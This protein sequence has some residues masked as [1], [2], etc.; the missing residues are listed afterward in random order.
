MG[1]AVGFGSSLARTV[2]F[3]VAYLGATYAGRLTVM[4]ATNLSLVWPAAGVSAVWAVV[5]FRSRWRTL[6]VVALSGVTIVVN[7]VTGAPAV[8]AGWFVAA[9]LL[10]A[11]IF[12]RLC[13]RWLPDAWGG[14]HVQPLSRLTELWRLVAAAFLATAGG[15]LVG[16]TGLWLTSGTYSWAATA[17]WLTRNTVSILL[18]G[19]A[20]VLV[21]K[22]LQT[23]WSASPRVSWH[24]RW[25]GLPA[26]RRAEYVSLTVLSIAVYGVVFGLDHRLPL[27][28]LVIALT[29]W[30][31]LR[32]NTTFVVLHDLVFGSVTVVFTLHGTGVFAQI[33]SHPARAMV[34][35]LFVG[36]IAVAGL[37]LALGRDDR[38]A[39]LASLTAAE[40]SAAR[41]A[42]MMGAIIDAMS[43]GLTVVDS[44]GRFLLRNPAVRRLMRGVVSDSDTMAKPEY[45]GLFHPDGR[46]LQPDEMPYRRA[47]A[48]TDVR[49]MDILIRNPGLPDGRVLSVSAVAL[50]EED[51]GRYA[52]SVFHDVTAERRHRDELAAFAGAVAHDLQNPL[53]TVEGWSEALAE[54]IGEVPEHAARAELADAVVRIRRASARM[55]N[56]IND[57]LEYTTARDAT[58]SPTM[59]DLGDLVDD[60]AMAR[61][62]Q[63]QSNGAP[64]P[65]F[66]VGELHPAYADP[67]LIR[68]LLENLLGN[69]IKYTARGTAAR[70]AVATEVVDEMVTV[71]IDDNGIGIPEGQHE[72]VFDN[73]HRAHRG[74]GHS[75]TGLGLGICKRIVERH[76][77]TIRATGNPAGSGTRLV[78]TLPATPDALA[79][80]QHSDPVTEADQAGPAPVGAAPP[81]DLSAGETDE[82]SL[83]PAATFEHAARLILDYL[84]DRIPLAFWAVTRV[85]NG[86]QTY[87][88]LDADNGYGL[89]QGESHPWQ[90][91]FCMHM[92]AG[93][94][95]SVARDAQQV[96]VYAAAGVNQLIDIGTYAGAAI[97]EPDGTLFGAICG[98]DPQTHTGDPRMTDAEPLLALLGRL[99]TVALAADRARD[100]SANAML[101]QQLSAETDALTGLPNR[102][103]W[104]RLIE[105]AETRFARLADPTVIAVLDLDGL[106][107]I[108]DSQGHGAGDTY[109]IVAAAAMHRA[110]RDTDVVARLGGD[111]FGFLLHKCTEDDAP[112]V[113]ARISA[114]LGKAGVRASIGW[115][116]VTGAESFAATVEKADAAMYATK[117]KNRGPRQASVTAPGA[118]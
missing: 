5:Q 45:Y 24:A 111:E 105:Q 35:Q 90:D 40:R 12:A 13:H 60:I 112:A 85:E 83:R 33:A 1:A 28:F 100:R 6:D 115:H 21:G 23:W 82:P 76:G 42:R 91:S 118:A 25:A 30:A 89:H 51:G 61:I 53:A 16:P 109:L 80:R 59:V 79:A 71:T 48:G 50:P 57:L 3:A 32:L 88:Y 102:R 87:L 68:Q 64:I 39:L 4:D 95:P 84:H 101:H 86:R 43:E 27:A 2:A 92:A 97:T 98:L 14:V 49:D 62:D 107:M 36:M 63:A 113:V 104:Q 108:N 110:L 29:M 44:Q 94:A 99:L 93:Q 77:G 38:A 20:T 58:L 17:V 75:G 81:A 52:V 54:I 18:I 47:L 73:F 69:A 66:V 37:A 46:P 65:A 19:A 55:R 78:L 117:L 41:Q 70:I 11:W 56:M 34:A 26:R 31:G 8:L 96:P 9:N 106:K 22:A 74:A 103:A 72:A 15:A 67:V 10:Q 7:L 114:E 116:A